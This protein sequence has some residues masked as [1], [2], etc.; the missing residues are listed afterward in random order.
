MRRRKSD[1]KKVKP[2]HRPQCIREILTT[3]HSCNRNFCYELSFTLSGID[4]IVGRKATTNKRTTTINRFAV[5]RTKCC[6]VDKTKLN[7]L[8]KREQQFFFFFQ[9]LVVVEK[10]ILS[11]QLCS[12]EI[13][14]G[15][16]SEKVVWL[17]S[18]FQYINYNIW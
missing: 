7:S 2:S 3:S 17:C 10:Y 15:R 12:R 11:L 8:C 6:V 5:V 14:L 13:I 16:L 1:K 18:C 9:F 4:K